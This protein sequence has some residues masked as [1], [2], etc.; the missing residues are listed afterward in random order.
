MN[1][2]LLAPL[3]SSFHPASRDICFL[4]F[5]DDEQSHARKGKY[6]ALR[7]RVASRQ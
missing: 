5:M 6:P 2:R 4:F 3:L 7:D 1:Q